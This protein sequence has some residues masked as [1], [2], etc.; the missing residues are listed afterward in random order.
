MLRERAAAEQQGTPISE[1]VRSRGGAA[2]RPLAAPPPVRRAVR[3]EHH[4]NSRAAGHTAAREASDRPSGGGRGR[5]AVRTVRRCD[6]ATGVRRRGEQDGD[7]R[8]AGHT[9]ETGARGPVRRRDG[10]AR[11]LESQASARV[12]SD[13]THPLVPTAPGRRSDG[14]TGGGW[15]PSGW[16][17]RGF[18]GGWAPRWW[19]TSISRVRVSRSG[20]MAASASP[21]R[22]RYYSELR[23]RAASSKAAIFARTAREDRRW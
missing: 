2:L 21:T 3:R 7:S 6:V 14:P 12:D 1:G 17:V 13:V 8:S 23:C 19:C 20:R 22:G 10:P 15:T 5:D 9:A 4:G 16:S 11:P 18:P